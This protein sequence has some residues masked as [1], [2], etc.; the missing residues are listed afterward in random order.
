MDPLPELGRQ[1]AVATG[2]RLPVTAVA[3][4]SDTVVVS[5]N[6]GMLR[7]HNTSHSVK[8]CI[9]EMTV[10]AH[11]RIHGILPL[12]TT[13]HGDHGRVLVFGSKSWT[14]VSIQLTNKNTIATIQLT[15]PIFATADWIKAAHWVRL[16]SQGSTRMLVALALAHNQALVCDAETGRVV[17]AAECCERSIL[18]AAA[19]AGDTLD[20]LVMAA[21]TVFNQVLVWRVG[22]GNGNGGCGRVERRL[23]GH[24]GVIFGVRFSSDRQTVAS[25]SDDRTLR[26]W[27]LAPSDCV[28]AVVVPAATL[29]GHQG[30][31]WQCL[32]LADCIVT[33]SED[34]TCRVWRRNAIGDG[35]GWRA[36]ESWR[37]CKKNVWAIAANRSQ[38]LVASG[39]GDG[40]L[41]AHALSAAA[42]SRSVEAADPRLVAVPLPPPSKEEAQGPKDHIRAFALLGWDSA[43]VATG[44]GHVLQLTIGT[45]RF[46]A[47]LAVSSP[48]LRGFAMAAG[49]AAG[50]LAAIGLRDGSVALIAGSS[51]EPPPVVAPLHSGPVQRLAI[52][53]T[54]ATSR[55][56]AR[57]HDLFT[58]GADADAVMWTQ[59]KVPPSGQHAPRWTRR[60][61]LALPF[62]ARFATATANGRWAA[63][64]TMRG[65]LIIYLLPPQAHSG[66]LQPSAFLPRI[67]GRVALSAIAITST[68]RDPLSCTVYT[69]GRDGMLHTFSV[70]AEDDDLTAKP[71]R[72]ASERLT[73]G[74]IEQ[75]LVTQQ[76]SSALVAVTFYRQRMVLVDHTNRTELL[77]VA[78]AGGAAKPWQVLYDDDGSVLFG[79]MQGGGL[80]TYHHQPPP[81][82]GDPLIHTHQAPCIRLI[83]GISAVDIR[84][85]A[86][87]TTST[88]GGVVLLATV[89]EDCCL[90]IHHYRTLSLLG[91]T[92]AEAA[93]NTTTSCDSLQLLAEARC[94]ASAIR[95]VAFIPP[96][97]H[98]GKDTR[99]L[100]TAGAGSELRC[101]RL[102]MTLSATKPNLVDWGAVLPANRKTRTDG[103]L[104]RIM[105]IAILTSSVDYTV[106]AAAYSDAS[107]RIWRLDIAQ[108]RFTCIAR[109]V[110]RTHACCVLSLATVTLLLD[111]GR[112]RCILLSGATNGQILV[113]DINVGEFSD[114][115]VADIG[116]PVL[117]CSDVHLSGVNTVDVCKLGE[118]RFLVVSGGDDNSVAMFG[119][120]IDSQSFR[121]SDIKRY[122][123]IHA[124]SVQ[125]VQFIDDATT[126]VSVSTDQRLVTWSVIEDGTLSL[127]HMSCI[128]VA[129]PSALAVIKDATTSTVVVVAGIGLQVFELN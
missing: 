94:H 73:P 52:A 37:Q 49:A 41:Q 50:G 66:T 74:W 84:D 56:C 46:A 60:A 18:Y 112:R 117:V 72:I 79:F 45:G 121:A 110:G 31:V 61:V 67:H 38:T 39:G 86:I 30:R 9:G 53:S 113:W 32:V 29:Y 92:T 76:P 22:N 58:A 87:T 47:R 75:L 109:D 91:K 51:D 13:D 97:H 96:P 55:G 54:A 125:R 42:S 33:S 80:F 44:S 126:V 124:S 48:E 63:V 103:E 100:L 85:T 71:T 23:V 114:G 3:F 24:E 40:S 64:G 68:A 95:C 119:I 20:D 10:F 127:L 6:G 1:A 98:H 123:G 69:G 62:G 59:V 81:Q 16:E 122:T 19:F 104:P 129:D 34:G 4:L 5:A 101:W 28:G 35:G 118:S 78:C 105:G 82:S 77:S 21:G 26:L 89:G 36:V 90:R 115:V 111:N 43:V 93:T 83:D 107:I 128:Q 102:D 7:V 27:S 99:Y 108:Q 8:A 70:T 2:S 15:T 11:A 116:P 14:I 120:D 106:F 12:L 25:V 65:G 17:H 57:T 88:M